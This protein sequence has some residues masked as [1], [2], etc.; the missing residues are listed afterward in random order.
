MTM[1][2]ELPGDTLRG[3]LPIGV[4]TLRFCEAEVLYSLTGTPPW[5]GGVPPEVDVISD[6]L[7]I[8]CVIRARR[9][10]KFLENALSKGA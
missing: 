3:Y 4:M 8:L 1:T 7:A 5:G 10:R 9:R 2:R 6:F